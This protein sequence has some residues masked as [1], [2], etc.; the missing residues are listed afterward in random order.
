MLQVICG[1]MFS[2]KTEEL[3]RRSKRF[4]IAKK[5]VQFFKPVVDQRYSKVNIVSH[6]GL[7][8]EAEAI[9]FAEEILELLYSDTAA[10]SID[11]V[12]FFD[13]KVLEVVKIL[14]DNQITVIVS[15]LD[16]DFKGDPFGQMPSLL[17]MAD[18]V[19][20]LKAVCVVCGNEANRTQRIVDGK[21]ASKTDDLV[22]IGGSENYEARCSSCYELS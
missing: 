20:K 18:E 13:A 2:G 21:P 14:L 16:L 12:Q 1:C 3:I 19:V 9:T 4:L 7:E 5:R 10:V 11:E 15:G 8:V 17:A 22:L 6:A